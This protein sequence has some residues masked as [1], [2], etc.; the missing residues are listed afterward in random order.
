[1][2]EAVAEI[3][4][5]SLLKLTSAEL[6]NLFL[7]MVIQAGARKPIGVP[8]LLVDKVVD[9]VKAAIP[10]MLKKPGAEKHFRPAVERFMRE[11]AQ[12]T[13]V[14]AKGKMATTAATFGSRRVARTSTLP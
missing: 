9:D 5:D 1:M 10:D 8:Q 7:P 11:A 3:A 4:G 6:K 2:R 14:G 12:T 13:L